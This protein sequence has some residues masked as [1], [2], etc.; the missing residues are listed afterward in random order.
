MDFVK[1]AISCRFINEEFRWLEC[2][3]FENDKIYF[4][5]LNSNI[6]IKLKDSIIK[7]ADILKYLDGVESNSIIPISIEQRDRILEIDT[8]MLLNTNKK[9]FMKKYKLE[10]WLI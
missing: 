1:Q 4:L 9:N 8:N 6:R 5:S 10:P 3:D 7:N 2:Y